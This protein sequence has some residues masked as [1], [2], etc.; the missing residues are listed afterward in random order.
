MIAAHYPL[1]ALLYA[2]ALHRYLRWRQPGYDP[3]A[4]SAACCTCSCAACAGRTRRSSTACRAGCSAGAPPPALVVELSELLDGGTSGDAPADPPTAGRSR[5]VRPAVDPGTPGSPARPPACSPSSTRPA[6][7]RRPT[8]TSPPGSAAGSAGSRRAGAARAGAGGAALRLGSVCLDLAAVEPHRARRGRRAARRLRRC[9]GRSPPA[10]SRRCR[11][12]PLVADG[13][14]APGGRPLRLVDGLLYLDRYW[15]QEESVRRSLRRARRA[16]AA[17]GRPAAA[18][19]RACERLFRRPPARDRAAAGRRGRR[20]APGHACSPAARAPARPPPSRGCWRCSHDQPGPAAADR[21][22]RAHRQGRGPAAGGRA[23]AGR[24]RPGCATGLPRGVA[25]CTGC[26][27]GGPA[28]APGSGTTATQP[29]ALRRGRGRRDLDGVADDDGPAA[30]GGAAGRPAGAGRR[31]RP[32]RLRRGRRGA[33][34]PR[35][36]PAAAPE[37]ALDAALAARCD[38]PRR[39]SRNGVVTL[40]HVWRFGGAIAELA[41]RSGPATPTPRSPCS[42]AGHDDLEF[43]ETTGDVDAVRRDVVGRRPGARPRPAAR[44]ATRPPRWPRWTS[45]GCCARTGA[46]P[47]ASPAGRPRSSAGCRRPRPRADEPWYPGRPLLVTAN[48]YD[49]GLFNGDTGV[50]VRPRRRVRG[51]RSPAAARRRCYPPSGCPTWPTVHAMTVHRGQGSQFRPGHRGAAAGR[52]RRCSPASCSTP[53][54]PGPGARAGGRHGGG[55]PG[56]RRAA[57]QPGQRAAQPAGRR[58]A[59]PIRPVTGRAQAR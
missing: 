42:R 24:C 7:S 43:A 50:V 36:G 34:R 39:R 32:A 48:D 10:G 15:R 51:P 3:S 4:T 31:P 53:R 58:T 16:A 38:L 41:A 25:R 55:R 22:G 27:A 21:A 2:V 45:T 6:C 49:I 12:G 56:R 47:T 57:G 1:Q 17:G 9:R 13:A 14:D 26:S 44:R 52:S 20:A 54:S 11:A 28:A 37:P 30:R 18:A 46:G 40:D 23:R 29:A 5:P 59:S 8:C 19:R 35:P 33:R